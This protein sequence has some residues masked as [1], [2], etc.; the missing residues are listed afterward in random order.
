MYKKST[1]KSKEP[2]KCENTALLCE[3]NFQII[4]LIIDNPIKLPAA[5][6]PTAVK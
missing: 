5:K 4:S 1:S 3:P 2:G 6:K